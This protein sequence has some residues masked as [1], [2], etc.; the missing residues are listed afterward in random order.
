[1]ARSEHRHVHIA[2][3][4]SAIL[5]LMSISAAWGAEKPNI[6]FIMG[7]DIGWMQVCSWWRL[8]DIQKLNTMGVFGNRR[9]EARGSYLGRKFPVRKR[10][11]VFR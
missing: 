10:C 8:L 1:M 4:A 7:D 11:N 6:L 9:L 2:V 5:A 3:Y